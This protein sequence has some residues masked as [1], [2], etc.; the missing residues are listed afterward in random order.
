MNQCVFIQGPKDDSEIEA[1]NGKRMPAKA[2]F[3]MA[4]KY[5]VEKIC[6][7]VMRNA[8]QRKSDIMF[9]IAVPAFWD[10][11]SKDLMTYA[12]IAVSY[13]LKSNFFR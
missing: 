6:D 8:N 13:I 9:V 1:V 10:E 3:S 5:I 7:P 2:V 12:A 11:E 4:I